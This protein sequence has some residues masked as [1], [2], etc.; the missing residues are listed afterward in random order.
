MALE[1]CIKKRLNHFRLDV[2]FK[3]SEGTTALLGAS[4]CGKSM[5]LRCIAGIEHP[6]EG[7]IVLDGRVLFDSDAHID[8]PPQRRRVGYLF[9]NYALFPHMTVSQNI[10]VGVRKARAQREHFVEEIIRA[11]SLGGH[12]HKYP[13]QLSGGQQQRVALARILANEPA[14]ILLDEPFSALDSFL[15]WQLEQNLMDTLS[16]FSGTTL[17][18]SHNLNEVYRICERVC[19]M[20]EGCCEPIVPTKELFERPDTVSAAR[21]SGCKN[22]V[23]ADQQSDPDTVLIPAWGALLHCGQAVS[24][25]THSI[26][27]HA[28]HLYP[29]DGRDINHIDCRVIRV[30]EDVMAIIVLL[31]PLQAAPDTQP[32]RMELAKEVWIA[33]QNPLMV[34]VGVMPQHILLLRS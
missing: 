10:A 27:I 15:K 9:Q 19:V 17:L 16:K 28:Y 20:N 4:G 21:L 2:H 3:A 24:E 11:F 33:Q 25:E 8:L 14:L 34:T 1:I 30:I 32:L 23:E 29:T 6:D 13:A 12:E 18:V 5:T 22:L 31:R 7:R 26:G